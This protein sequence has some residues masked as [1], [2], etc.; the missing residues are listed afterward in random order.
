MP[1][2]IKCPCGKV[3]RVP[4][5][6]LGKR[7]KC[8]GCGRVLAVS[9]EAGQGARGP[10]ESMEPAVGRC[11]RCGSAIAPGTRVC[12]ECGT[13]LFTG[14]SLGATRA[15]RGA[16]DGG[17]RW[18]ALIVGGG[19]VALMAVVAAV[20]TFVLLRGRGRPGGIPTSSP[21]VS[22]RAVSRPTARREAPQRPKPRERPRP[23]DP[24]REFQERVVSRA[25]EN[26]ATVPAGGLVVGEV[27]GGYRGTSSMFGVDFDLEHVPDGFRVV[28]GKTVVTPEGFEA[29]YGVIIANGVSGGDYDLAFDFLL[30]DKPLVEKDT[31]PYVARHEGA[32]VL[33][34]VPVSLRVTVAEGALKPEDVAVI[35]RIATDYRNEARKAH[36]AANRELSKPIIMIDGEQEKAQRSLQRRMQLVARFARKSLELDTTSDMY[37]HWLLAL[38]HSDDAALAERAESTLAEEVATAPGRLQV[39]MGVKLLK[40]P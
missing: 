26:A 37:V 8:P 21:E 33:A 20:V 14:A 10:T 17:T 5:S 3:L 15:G 34:T 29:E 12:V 18:T 7:V 1:A 11:P 2:T 31:P 30:L 28:R 6:L 24:K 27:S 35:A 22:D 38:R 40:S 39:G 9:G 19:V 25:R 36:A 13:D 4:D 23:L 16:G 32:R